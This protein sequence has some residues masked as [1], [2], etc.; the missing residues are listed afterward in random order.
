MEGTTNCVAMDG[1]W[2]APCAVRTPRV[3]GMSRVEKACG[4][5]DPKKKPA[6]HH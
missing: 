2:P 6:R 4:V 5:K 3:E 1:G